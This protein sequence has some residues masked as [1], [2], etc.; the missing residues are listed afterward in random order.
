LLKTKG[1]S[2][3]AQTKAL[4]LKSEDIE[5][6]ANSFWTFPDSLGSSKKKTQLWPTLSHTPCRTLRDI[7]GAMRMTARPLTPSMKRNGITQASATASRTN[8]KSNNSAELG[9][10]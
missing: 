4:L 5:A 7:Q 6:I 10:I 1:R 9:A 3:T 8:A 2:S